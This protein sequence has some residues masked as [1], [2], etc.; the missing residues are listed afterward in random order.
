MAEP[1]VNTYLLLLILLVLLFGSSA[2]LGAFHVALAV[3]A[4]VGVLALIAIA[5]SAFLGKLAHLG[6]WFVAPFRL[7]E[8]APVN[9]ERV[10]WMR[11]VLCL[12]LGAALITA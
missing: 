1:N 2:V 12:V 3:L 9:E 10:G 7:S 11:R 6:A 8:A 4:I 5:F